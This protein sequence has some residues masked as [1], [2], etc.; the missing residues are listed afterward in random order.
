[1]QKTFSHSIFTIVTVVVFNI[2]HI[3]IMNSNKIINIQHMNPEIF[4]ILINDIFLYDIP[5][6]PL[7]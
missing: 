5:F 2:I 7:N 6:F 1:M 3:I 4:Y